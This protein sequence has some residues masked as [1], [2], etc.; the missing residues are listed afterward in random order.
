MRQ[1]LRRL[2][3]R[4]FLLF[5]AL[6]LNPGAAALAN[7]PLG[8]ETNLTITVGGVAKTLTLPEAMAEL[9]IPAVSVALIDEDRI[10]FARAYGAGVTTETLFQA[11]SLS[12][13]VAA[14]GAMRLVE[15]KRLSLDGDVM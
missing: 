11:A 8:L 9:K 10:A 1:T 2:L 7:D 15:R 4:S 5:A 12:K 13:F 3:V 6:C 14:I